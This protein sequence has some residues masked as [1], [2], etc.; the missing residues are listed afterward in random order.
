MSLQHA[1]CLTFSFGVFFTM[2]QTTTSTELL[3]LVGKLQAER[4]DHVQ[5]I[6]AIDSTFQ[7]LGMNIESMPAKPRRGRPAKVDQPSIKPTRRGRGGYALTGD[8]LVLA[9]VQA[10]P[11]C[12]TAQVNEHWIK[13]GRSGMA[14]NTLAKLAKAGKLTRMNL[15]GQRGSTF[16]AR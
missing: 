16:T 14:S 6:E 3:N 13:E 15:K 8:E 5:A 1:Q 4:A 9:F 11:E 12:T 7:Q 2:S 10:N